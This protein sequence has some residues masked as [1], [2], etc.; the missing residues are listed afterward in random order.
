M[1]REDPQPA[2][3]L[4]VVRLSKGGFEPQSPKFGAA[5]RDFD[6]DG[7]GGSGGNSGRGRVSSGSRG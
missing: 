6:V 5:P 3:L 1:G 7:G 4:E 2:L